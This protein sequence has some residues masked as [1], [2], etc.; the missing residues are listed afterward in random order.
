MQDSQVALLVHDNQLLGVP[1][2]GHGQYP[3]PGRVG[4]KPTKTDACVPRRELTDT[5]VME[6]HANKRLALGDSIKTASAGTEGTSAVAIHLTLYSQGVI[7]TQDFTETVDTGYNGAPQGGIRAQPE[8]TLL[9]HGEIAKLP[10][11]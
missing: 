5:L 7:K 8:N 2:F 11:R 6:V 9:A 1:G 10:D 3:L 4:N